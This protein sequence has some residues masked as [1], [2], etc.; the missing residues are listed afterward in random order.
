M[1]VLLI[2]SALKKLCEASHNFFRGAK[3]PAGMTNC[4]AT[5]FRKLAFHVNASLAAINLAKAACKKMGI[6]YSIS[7]C[8]SV[9]HNA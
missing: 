2:Y 8:K 6:K 7:S 1:Q 3:Q 5:D 4:Q 9:I